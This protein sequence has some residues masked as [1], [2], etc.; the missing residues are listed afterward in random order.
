MDWN[1][2]ISQAAAPAV[3]SGTVAAVGFFLN[4]SLVKSMHKER[5]D[6]DRDQADRRA[7]AEIRL[8]EGK[9]QFDKELAARKFEFDSRL[10]MQKVAHD[11]AD[12][13][14]RRRFEIAEQVLSAA[15]EARGA[16]D[17]SR[18]R[19][20][21]DGEGKTRVATEAERPEIKVARDSAFIPVERL[22][23]HSK[24][25]ATLQ[26]L[27][28]AVSAHLG[29]EAVQ[30]IGVILGAYLE[31]TAASAVLMELATA[32]DDRQATSSIAPLN[33]A[34]WGDAAGRRNTV[35]NQ[36]IGRLEAICKPILLVQAPE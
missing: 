19:G 31:I 22:L 8:A 24:S 28:D 32:A 5:L 25:F 13:A 30:P 17:W 10:A 21:F 12:V 1:T 15:Y 2:L 34:L 27:S 7:A 23:S 6:F 3:I 4:R 35:V 9:S 20:V 11:R 29:P 18:G 26:T 14:W 16:I 33:D 36:A